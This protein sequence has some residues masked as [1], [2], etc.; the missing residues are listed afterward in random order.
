MIANKFRHRNAWDL[1]K[2]PLLIVVA[3][4]LGWSI[5]LTNLSLERKNAESFALRESAQLAQA[6]ADHLTR[7]F[8][9]VDQIAQHVRYEWKLSNGSLDLQKAK[10]DGLFPAPELVLVTIVNRDGK[11]LNSTVPFD[12]DVNV[13]D[14]EHFR[15]HKASDT[16]ILY[17]SQ[18]IVG[19]VSRKPVIQFTRRIVDADGSFA[20]VVVVSVAP[21]FF[22]QAF[23]MNNIGSSGLLAMMGRDG[24][25]RVSRIGDTLSAPDL[26]AIITRM[27]LDSEFGS[28][29]YPGS[30]WFSDAQSRFIG[31]YALNR[32]PIIAVAGVDQ[33]AVLASYRDSRGRALRAGAVATLAALALAL[34]ATIMADRLARARQQAESVRNAYR[35]ATDVGNDGFFI[36]QAIHN[37]DG[38]L[39]DLKLMDCNHRGAAM[40][41]KERTELLG[42][43]LSSLYPPSYFPSVLAL[44]REAMAH[45]VYEDEYRTGPHNLA[46]ATWLHRKLLRSG[47]SIAVTLRD[48]SD[49]KK[50]IEELERRGNE[51]ALTTLHNRHWLHSYL[52]QALQRLAA[53]DKQLALLFIDIDGF[54]A[55]NDALG[56]N[57]GDELLRIAASRLKSILRPQDNVVRLGG[58]EFLL[59]LEDIETEADAAHVSTRVLEAFSKKFKL[60]KGVLELGVSIGISIFPKDGTVAET[61][62]QNA[63]VAM[64]SAK[65]SGKSQFRFYDRAFYAH[66]LE[67]LEVERS[68]RLAI[69]LDQFEMF[70]QPRVDMVSGRV[71]GLE[72]LIRWHHPNNGLVNPVEFIGIA[73]ETGLIKGLGKQVME[74]VCA[75]I[76]NWS[77]QHN[78]EVPVSINVSPQQFHDGSVHE[79]LTACLTRFHVPPR[80]VEIEVT[81]S[82]MMGEESMVTREMESLQ[83]LGVKLLVDDFGTGYSSLAQLQRLDMDGLKIDR[84]F[85]S[86]LGRTREGEV[87]VAAIVTMAHALGMRVVA[88]GVETEEQMAILKRLHCDE[89]QGYLV[90]RPVPAT[91]IPALVSLAAG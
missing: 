86:E 45:G 47:D 26:P 82:S 90:S 52:P 78:F 6:Y 79:F 68:L 80:L 71:C 55:V 41:G 49:T 59:I 53:S 84:A 38:E 51:D 19:R 39:V 24:E 31:W 54:K 8:D 70:Y 13:A 3:A 20:G 18:V 65:K 50:H 81:E 73:E 43:H 15:V 42:V 4:I 48:I 1:A 72:A 77:S 37:D 2:W 74:K 34:L 7:A 76:A 17:I 27:P 63:D 12:P 29:F 85:T 21:A 33:Q 66:L 61:L 35:M 87:F 44:G 5:L 83:A 57:A 9:A 69:E 60:E 11:P 67:R 28:R 32:Y 91:E 75:Q 64:Y 58:D 36:F 62:L 40:V 88:E 56:H 22:A 16:D 89:A 23:N 46:R 25:I 30:G 10:N 14:R